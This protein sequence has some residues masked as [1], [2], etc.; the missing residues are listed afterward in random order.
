MLQLF[1]LFLR[2]RMFFFFKKGGKLKGFKFCDFA[3]I[4]LSHTELSA[5][6]WLKMAVQ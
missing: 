1:F 6:L 2:T 5:T 3:I 4:F